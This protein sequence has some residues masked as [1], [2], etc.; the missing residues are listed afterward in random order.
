MLRDP[1]CCKHGHGI[2]ILYPFLFQRH[3]WLLSK[4]LSLVRRMTPVD[5]FCPFRSN[6]ISPVPSL[7]S[8]SL[9]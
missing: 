6:L 3:M 1:T 9:F 4:L 7:L 8:I 5:P 2:F